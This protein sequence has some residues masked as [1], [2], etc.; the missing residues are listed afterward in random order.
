MKETPERDNIEVFR[1]LSIM[2]NQ[3]VQLPVIPRSTIR[4]SVPAGGNVPAPHLQYKAECLAA[5]NDHGCFKPESGPAITCR[6]RVR[7][8]HFQNMI[9]RWGD[10]HQSLQIM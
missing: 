4:P 6:K 3:R 2:A 8:I 10:H 1:P 5:K 7:C 9:R